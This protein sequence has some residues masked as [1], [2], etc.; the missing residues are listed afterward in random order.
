MAFTKGSSS[1]GSSS[2]SL[3][4]EERNLLR[5]REKECRN[6]EAHQEKE[7]FPEKIPL[8]GEPYKKEKCDELSSRLQTM[9]GDYEEVKEFLSPRSHSCRPSASDAKPGKPRYPEKGSSLAAHSLRPGVQRHQ[10]LTT[11]TSAPLLVVPVSHSS[12]MAQQRLEPAP[13]VYTKGCAPL[14]SQRLAQDCL[15]LEGY[16]SGH[17]K[18]GTFRAAGSQCATVAVLD[19]GRELSPRHCATSALVP[20]LSPVHCSQVLSTNTSP[21]GLAVRAPNKEDSQDS[22]MALTSLGVT[23]PPPPLPSK[24]L[25]MQQKPTAYVRPMDGQDQVP[26]ESPNLKPLLEDYRLQTFEKTGLK[27]PA[28]AKLTK[29]KIPA[30]S[31]ELTYSNE[32]HCVEEILKEMTHSWPPPLTAIHTPSTAEPSKF[33]FPTKDSQHIKSATQNQKQYDTSSQ[34]HLNSQ[35]G[36]SMLEDDL[37]LSDSEDSDSEQNSEKPP[38]S[39]APPSAPQ[40]L[41]APPSTTA[42]TRSSSAESESTSDSDSSSDSESESSSSDSEENEPPETPAPEPEPPSTNKWQLD[43]WLTKVSQPVAPPEALGTSQ[44][45]DGDESNST[46]SES[47]EPPPK[48]SSR[49]PRVPSEG[50]HIGKRSCQKASVLQEP[51]KR[52]TVGTKQPKR[53]SKAPAVTVSRPSLQ[54]ESEVSP[55]P[56]TPREQPSKDKPKVKTKGRP[57]TGESK[58]P[59]PREKKRHRGGPPAPPEACSGPELTKDLVDT[60]HLT[61]A[62]PVHGARSKTSSSQRTGVAPEENRKDPKM[63]SQ[64][65]DPSPPDQLLV[66]ITLSLLSRVP[67]PPGKGGCQKNPDHKQPPPG[68]RADCEKRSSD[69]GAKRNKGEGERDHDSKKLKLEKEIKSRSSSSSF[70]KDSSKTKTARSS[71]ESS[72]QEMLSPAPLSSTSS[73]KPSKPAQKRSRQEVEPSGQDHPRSANSAKGSHKDP[74]VPKHRK[75]EG[76]SSGSSSE[77]KSSSGDSTSP[78]PVPSL[79]NGNPKPGR[80]PLKLE[81]PQADIHMKE[82]RRL[83]QKA[84]TMKDKAGK[85]VKYLEAALSFIESG[86]AMESE[87]PVSKAAHAVYSEALELLSFTMSLKAFSSAASTQEKTFAVL[88]LRCQSLLNM[89]MFRCRKD[90]VLK[91]SRALN[92]HFHN[93]S[94]VARAPSPC[95]A[96]NTGTPSSLSPMPSPASSQASAGGVGTS[97]MPLNIQNMTSSYVTITSHVLT[98][99]ELWEQAEM[100]IRKNKDLFAQLSTNA[101]ALALNSS[102]SDLVHYARQGLQQLKQ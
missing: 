64:L 101:C 33:P 98:A 65:R 51:P 95:I 18:K 6:Q 94:K 27:V 38:S 85:A 37:Q 46:C 93:A 63:L 11:P 32:V 41:P 53:P 13:T 59:A 76:R 10:L 7:A 21:P 66:R 90:T 88:C 19:A 45:K 9:L 79:P 1:G 102:L 47:K 26:S 22:I 39:S 71:L 15:S 20:Q 99:F 4:N 92:E 12:K 49:A 24:S 89:A 16:D 84:E 83:K 81:K 80:P 87:G 44:G 3:Y 74:S 30:Q 91:Y 100:L 29:L 70:H 42:A 40:S 50:P 62:A 82:A 28:R 5:I 25:A 31:V 78:F 52:Q 69:K 55:S 97:G 8:F 2:N 58:E 54:V 43:N 56:F 23:F 34:T 48:S 96:R 86:I 35:Q 67:R 57:R 73:Q 61:L 68:K 72:K 77:H 36:T 17:L 75:V 14:D 60:R